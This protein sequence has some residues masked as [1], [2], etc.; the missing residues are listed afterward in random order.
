MRAAALARMGILQPIDLLT[1][2][3]RDWQD[4]R[5]RFNLR[6]APL[7][8]KHT[9][10]AEITAVKFS[11]LR[12]NLGLATATL[13]DASGSLKAVWFKKINP[14]YD[15]F[16]TLRGQLEPGKSLMVYGLVERGIEGRQIHVEEMAVLTEP[17]RALTPE[18][19]LHLNRIVPLYSVT[20][21]L[22]ERLLRSLIARV[23]SMA[24]QQPHVIPGW[25]A[26]SRQLPDKAWALKNIHF[27]ESR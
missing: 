11:T 3:P 24:S 20:E 17:G 2:F 18:D 12:R 4:R 22:G 10:T 14:R 15:V 19:A 26:K 5:H 16:A 23:I 9:L 8:E 6:E 25:L 27:P 21:G 13:Q 1:T 7:G